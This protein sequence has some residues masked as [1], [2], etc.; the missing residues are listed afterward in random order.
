MGREIVHLN[1]S[2]NEKAV[3]KGEENT[4]F[5]QVLAKIKVLNQQVLSIGLMRAGCH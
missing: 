4:L 2:L 5:A 1:Q 3:I